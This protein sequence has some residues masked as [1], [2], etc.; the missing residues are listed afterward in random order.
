MEPILQ[1]FAQSVAHAC[2]LVAVVF[3]ALGAAEAVGRTLVA[4]RGYGDVRLKKRIWL[5]FAASIILALEFA[6]AADIARTAISP[7]WNDIGQLA[8]I[9]AI[10]TL[11]NLF[12]ERD[13]DAARREVAETN[14]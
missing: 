9:A 4:W 5:R 12:L 11:L 7:T 2:E 6:L 8:A 14:S 3:I 13:L 1:D 10:R